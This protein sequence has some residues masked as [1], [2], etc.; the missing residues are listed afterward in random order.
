[1][2]YGL[3][4]AL[5][6][7][8]AQY[9]PVMASYPLRA[10]S[11]GGGTPNLLDEAQCEQLMSHV[12]RIFRRAPEFHTTVDLSPHAATYE[13]LRTWVAQGASR[14]S[15]GVQTL[16][17]SV[18]ERIHRDHQT[19]DMVARA[20]E[21]ARRA[22]VGAVCVDLVVGLPG[23]T[24]ASFVA[25]LERIVGLEP[26]EIQIFR[27]ILEPKCVDYATL[28][29]LS[30]ERLAERER[31][32]AAADGYLRSGKLGRAYTGAAS[33]SGLE[34]ISTRAD[35]F[36]VFGHYET[37]RSAH[38]SVLGVGLGAFSEV[39]GALTYGHAVTWDD[40]VTWPNRRPQLPFV[41]ATV[42]PTFDMAA[43]WAKSLDSASLDRADFR[44]DFGRTPEQ[45]FPD[46]IDFLTRAGWLRLTDDVYG[47][48]TELPREATASFFGWIPPTCPC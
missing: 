35:L 46:E 14:M 28:G 12:F 11:I 47:V 23:E 10:L 33:N 34:Y 25:T 13:K 24:E 19:F 37:V 38:A 17:T 2:R 41:G 43:R 1:M 6:F 5:E 39:S 44:R 21:N 29:P 20:L 45:V 18:L 36:H 22:G 16:T 3:L 31:I 48:P 32:L 9:E 40:Y 15:F 27:W 7:E 30:D 8:L 26:D 42:S 4:A